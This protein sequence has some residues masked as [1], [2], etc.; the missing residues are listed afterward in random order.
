MICPK[1]EAANPEGATTCRECGRPLTDAQPAGV[2]TVSKTSDTAVA[3]L[4]CGILGWSVLPVV[5]AVLAI[6]LGHM[7]RD[8]IHRSNGALGGDTMAA[9]G[10]AF[11]YGGLALL[12]A[13]IMLVVLLAVL[14][15][16]IPVGLGL[17]GLC[18]VFGA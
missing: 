18:A 10:L 3:S 8:E 6:I 12:A 5:G 13:A 11:G 17:C 9:L 2:R 14:G 4:I 7:A 15:I 16:A 1:C